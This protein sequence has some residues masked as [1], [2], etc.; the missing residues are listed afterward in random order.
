M[1]KE[2]ITNSSII[3]ARE[4]EFYCKEWLPI[5]KNTLTMLSASGGSGKSFVS[6]QLAIQLVSKNPNAKVLLWLSEDPLFIIKNRIDKIFS[7]IL[8]AL[9]G[10]KEE[11]LKRIDIIGAE[12]ETIYFNQLSDDKLNLIGDELAIYNFIV[13]DPLIAFYA[14]EENSNSEARKFMNIL[15]KIATDRRLSILLIHHHNKEENSRTRGA[16]AFVDA[17]RVLYTISTIKDEESKIIH[18][19]KRKIK[20]K[21]DNWGVRQLLGYDSFTR[22]V[23]P[24]VVKEVKA[25]KEEYE[26]AN[27]LRT[28][29]F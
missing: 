1:I 5:P 27:K 9:Q 3:E 26:K 16:S 20:I 23:L 14:G 12:Q 6:I 11:I 24:Y 10:K 18:P 21:K 17:V 15:N 29:N 25:T 19:T 28:R 22:E 4:P 2:K 7:R 13:I 8:P